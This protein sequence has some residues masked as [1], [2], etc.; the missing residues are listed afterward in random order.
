M[1]MERVYF[2]NGDFAPGVWREI[3]PGRNSIECA[4][5]G[6]GKVLVYRRYLFRNGDRALTV[7]SANPWAAYR[8]GKRV[9]KFVG[10]PDSHRKVWYAMCFSEPDFVDEQLGAG[11]S[12]TTPAGN[13]SGPIG[14][15]GPIDLVERQA[16]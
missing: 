3:E 5:H 16:A 4:P 11:A 1:K 9:P 13:D 8:D 6:N 2:R 12:E 7:F 15:L 10:E 14:W